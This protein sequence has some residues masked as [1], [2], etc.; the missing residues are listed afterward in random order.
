MARELQRRDEEWTRRSADL[1]QTQLDSLSQAHA[2]EIGTVKDAMAAEGSAEVR[3]ALDESKV[4][5]FLIFHRTGNVTDERRVSFIH[6]GGVH[7]AGVDAAI[8]D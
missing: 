4:R 1:I 6:T 5:F 2:R 7:G 8:G 3:R